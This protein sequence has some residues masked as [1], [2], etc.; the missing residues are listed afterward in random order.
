SRDW[1]SDVCSSDLEPG[2][3]TPARLESPRFLEIEPRFSQP[4]A[5]L[6]VGKTQ[7]LVCV[8]LTQELQR[9]RGE[10]DDRQLPRRA[11]QPRC[12]PDRAARI[13][14]IVQYL[15]DGHEIETVARDRR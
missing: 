7:A 12:L 14:E 3:I 4:F 9:M 15:V 6:P 13:I 1:S 11:Q 5:D 10:I 2:R 8:F